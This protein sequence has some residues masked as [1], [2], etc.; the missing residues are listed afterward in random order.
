MNIKCFVVEPVERV[1]GEKETWKRLDTG[2]IIEVDS[3]WDLPV[4]AIF[5]MSWLEGVEGYCGPDGKS[6]CVITPGGGWQVDSR[7]SNCTKPDDD[8]HKCW[9]RHGIPP[10]VTVD[11]IGNTCAAGAGS[12]LIGKYHGF[13]R[14]GELTDC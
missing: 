1:G 13:L 9:V 8:I 6:L 12:I 2:E 7:A 14:N 4:G 11:K 10:K 5:F 3:Y